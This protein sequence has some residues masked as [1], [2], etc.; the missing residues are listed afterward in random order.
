MKKLG[1]RLCIVSISFN[2]T[3]VAIFVQ[4]FSNYVQSAIA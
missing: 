2:I 1:A 4:L 3:E